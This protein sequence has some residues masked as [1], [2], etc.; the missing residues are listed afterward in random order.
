MTGVD[1]CTK[2]IVMVTALPLLSPVKSKQIRP[3][4]PVAG[5]LLTAQPTLNRQVFFNAIREPL[6]NNSLKHSQINGIEAILNG[7]QDKGYTD[8]RW[9]A[10]MLATTH[11][12]TA[13]T[14]QPLKEYGSNEFLRLN[15]DISGRNPDK[16]RLMGN[17]APGDGVKFAGRGFVQLTWKN[18][19]RRAG[20]H[21]GIDLVGNPN[22]A[23]ELPV[24]TQI[25]VEGMAGGWFTG[26][27]LG[28]YFNDS[29]AD[30]TSARHIINGSDRAERIGSLA[31]L[32]YQA[33][34]VA[35]L[36][37]KN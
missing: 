29:R 22:K 28:D 7:W 19:Y 2:E 37:E 6:F 13:F 11:H 30:W 16:A 17:T 26:H 23:L 10:Y 20:Q 8:L 21:L 15:Y 27:K 12:E 36:T 25:L 3:T 4:V 33:L 14:M 32:F 5:P 1:N 34:M 31:R 18:N 35:S 9:L 24:A